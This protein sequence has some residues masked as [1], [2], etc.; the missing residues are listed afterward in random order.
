LKGYIR[1]YAITECFHPI[2]QMKNVMPEELHNELEHL[3]ARIREVLAPGSCRTFGGLRAFFYK[4]YARQRWLLTTAN[5][6]MPLDRNT[7]VQVADWLAW[8]NPDDGRFDPAG[9]R[10]NLAFLLS[11][12]A[13]RTALRAFIQSQVAVTEALFAFRDSFQGPRAVFYDP[14]H[15][16]SSETINSYDLFHLLSN[17]HLSRPLTRAEFQREFGRTDLKGDFYFRLLDWREPKLTLELA[18]DSQDDPAEFERKWGGAPVGMSGLRL[19]AREA[20]GDILSGALPDEVAET[21]ADKAMVVFIIPPADL[22]AMLSRLRGTAVWSRRLT[23]YLPD[24]TVDDGYRIFIG[25]AA[26]EA[27]AELQGHFL[28][29]DRVKSD[30]IIL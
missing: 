24:G 2:Y 21:L 29:K 9:L 13:Q 14:R 27:H 11:D 23:V 30:A 19:L 6:E 22:G 20:G 25:K 4:Y 18:Y 26:F 10:P 12:D 1:S 16:L 15:R 28:M 8:L 3:F 7:A 5:G 17:Y